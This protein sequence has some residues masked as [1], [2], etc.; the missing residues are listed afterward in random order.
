MLCI[1]AQNTINPP[2]GLFE[3]FL[4]L[5]KDF[6]LYLSAVFVAH[7]SVK[8]SCQDLGSWTLVWCSPLWKSTFSV[9]STAVL[10]LDIKR[11]WMLQCNQ[12]IQC[13]FVFFPPFLYICLFS[14][15]LNHLLVWMFRKGINA[16]AVNKLSVVFFNRSNHIVVMNIFV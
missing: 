7:I 11:R 16:K 6:K 2:P 8:K 12:R 13:S 15:Q 1:N 5:W 4:V 14:F 3:H 9:I 10:M